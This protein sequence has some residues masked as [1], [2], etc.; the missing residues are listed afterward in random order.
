[1]GIFRPAPSVLQTAV[2]NVHSSLLQGYWQCDSANMLLFKDFNK[3]L[4]I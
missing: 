3:F 2:R 1:M 4:C